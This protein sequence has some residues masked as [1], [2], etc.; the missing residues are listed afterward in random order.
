[1]ALKTI[2]FFIITLP[3]IT[4]KYG[5]ILSDCNISYERK[6]IDFNF[7]KNKNFSMFS[8]LNKQL[9][10]LHLSD[11]IISFEGARPDRKRD[12]HCVLFLQLFL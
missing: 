12:W 7:C 3:I 11:G 2:L 5:P 9:L 1:M 10:Y 6:E 8:F 4:F